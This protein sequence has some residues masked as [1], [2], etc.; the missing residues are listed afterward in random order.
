MPRFLF[1]CFSGINLNSPNI[2]FGLDGGVNY[3]N[4]ANL[5]KSKM[6]PMFNLGFYF[7]ITAQK[8]VDAAHRGNSKIKHGSR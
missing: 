4:I 2:E 6:L 3:G 5:E 1:L 8:P 7:D